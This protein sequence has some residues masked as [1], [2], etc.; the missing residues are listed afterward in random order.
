M[1]TKLSPSVSGYLVSNL[2]AFCIMGLSKF[3]KLQDPNVLIFSE[4][5]IIPLLMGIISAW[6]WRGLKLSGKQY[7]GRACLN[8]C[9]AIICSA[10]FLHE[11]VICLVI[12]SPVLLTLLV[13]GTFAGREMF[14]RNQ[15]HLNVSIL[16]LLLFTMLTDAFTK[17]H[18]VNE[19][20]DQVVI[21]APVGR[22]WHYVVAYRKNTQPN[23]YWLFKMGM[24]SPVQSTADG[25]HAG[26]NRKCIFSNGYVFDEKIV[27]YEKE[28]NLTFDVTN[29]PRDPEI[30]N[31]IDIRRGQFILKDNGNN[32]TTLIGNS[33]YELH[34]FPTWYY[35][36]WAQSV[37]RNV[38]LRVM[39]YIKEL[40]EAR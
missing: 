34:V 29:Q 31:H 17:H 32:T 5:F 8:A 39:N 25:Y 40:S 21:N 15:Q 20:S 26:A 12:V 22:V 3:F 7:V 18:Y 14:K 1:K 37:T 10:A 33:W 23:Q 30:M 9:I 6:Y 11:G 2:V 4:F 28:K 35:D 36:L 19:V 27:V 24:P 38:H 16:T 13:A